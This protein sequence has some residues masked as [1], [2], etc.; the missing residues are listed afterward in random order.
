MLTQKQRE[1]LDYIQVF[2]GINGYCPSYR[3]MQDGV[4]LHSKSG[5]HRL[6][7]ALEMRG[8]ITRLHGKNRAIKIIDYP[9]QS[10]LAKISDASL[11]E[12]CSRR[13]LIKFATV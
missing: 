1:L 11:L 5:V 10:S 7:D 12:E 13:G 8:Y 9:D 2:E 3:E 6:I 4:G